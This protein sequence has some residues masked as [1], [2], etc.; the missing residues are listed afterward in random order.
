MIYIPNTNTDPARNLAMEEYILTSSGIREPVL[1]FYVNAPSIIIG[2]HQNTPDEIDT[3]YVREHNIQIVR[4]CSGGGAVYHDFGN[5]NYSLIRPGDQKASGDFSLLLTPILSALHHLGLSAELS[6]RNDL[7]LN[8]A[9]FSG[10]AYY[11]NRFGSVTHG[12]L[13][14]DSDLGILSRALRPDPEKLSSKGVQSVRSRVC[15]IKPYLPRINNTEEL[16][17]A[18]LCHFESTEN[19][20]VRKFNDTDL[21]N[22]EDLANSRYRSDTW[23]YGES[24]AYNIRRRMRTSAGSVDFRAD[25]RG[26]KIHAARFFGDF[27][28]GGDICDMENALTGVAWTEDQLKSTLIDAGWQNYFPDFPVTEFIEKLQFPNH[29][30]S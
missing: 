4:R 5:V 18:I 29:S 15:C 10:N 27:F 16:V 21:M 7:L 12:T 13:L 30:S 28:C 3:G 17:Q 19:L 8:G 11:H 20:S 24:P 9:K 23:T 25:I 1:F 26:D 6:G 22:I 14:Y 2:R